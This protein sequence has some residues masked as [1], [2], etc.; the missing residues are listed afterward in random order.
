MCTLYSA[1]FVVQHAEKEDLD[2]RKHILIVGVVWLRDV[3]CF[4]LKHKETFH[5][6]RC[7]CSDTTNLGTY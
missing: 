5:L 4:S 3:N 1:N 7:T 6:Y 2:Q